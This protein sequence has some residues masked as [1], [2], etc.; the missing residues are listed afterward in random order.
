MDNSNLY[1]DMANLLNSL[2]EQHENDFLMFS[3]LIL[4]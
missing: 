2:V 1:L 3:C 4:I